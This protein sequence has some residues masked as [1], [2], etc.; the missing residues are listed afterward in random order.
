[1]HTAA[2]FVFHNCVCGCGCARAR[3]EPHRV[4]SAAL[5][6]QACDAEGAINIT[7]T[8]C[9][10]QRRVHQRTSPERRL[11]TVAHRFLQGCASKMTFVYHVLWSARSLLVRVASQ[12]RRR[13][14][15]KREEASGRRSGRVSTVEAL[16]PHPLLNPLTSCSPIKT[17]TREHAR[18]G[19]CVWVGVSCTRAFPRNTCFVF[20]FLFFSLKHLPE[21]V[22]AFKGTEKVIVIYTYTHTNT[23][24]Y[25]IVRTL[26]E[27]RQN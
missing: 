10:R 23:Q 8:G 7:G 22:Q 9:S 12:D 24:L 21:L 13:K 6:A 1:M 3:A 11:W 17:T 20:C 14:A 5:R 27:S 2:D 19:G 4:S 18:A 16:K 15:M 26:K 25:K